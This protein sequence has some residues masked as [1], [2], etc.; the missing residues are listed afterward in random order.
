MV[1]SDFWN[2][3]KKRLREV[4]TAAADFTEE[5]ALVGKLK[6]DILSLTRKID[7]KQREIGVRM[8]ELS[9]ESRRVQPFNDGDIIRLIAE[10]EEIEK[11]AEDKRNEITRVADQIRAKREAQTP[12]A[13]DVH[14]AEAPAGKPKAKPAPSTAKSAVKPKRKP[15]GTAGK[16]S[17]NGRRTRYKTGAKTGAKTSAAKK[18]DEKSSASK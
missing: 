18:D 14:P 10:I 2:K 16:K 7:R 12:T 13:A 5:Q 17:G 4:S 15:A 3:L 8:C 11:Q 6:F 9:R 1:Q